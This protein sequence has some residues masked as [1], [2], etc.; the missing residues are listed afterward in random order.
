MPHF[1]ASNIT[2]KTIRQS[3]IHSGFSAL[4]DKQEEDKNDVEGSG[5]EKISDKLEKLIVKPRR[6]LKNI[7]FN[8]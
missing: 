8:P 4:K 5:L 7:Q 6:K 1:K 2:G 3:V